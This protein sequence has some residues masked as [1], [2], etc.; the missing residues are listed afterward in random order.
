MKPIKLEIEGLN[1]YATKQVVDFETLTSRGLFGIFGKTGSGKS[2]ILDAITLS[3]YG[4][5][6]RGTKEFINSNHDKASID[7]EFELGESGKRAVYKVSRRFKRSKTNGNSL[8]DYARLVRKSSSG[9]YEILADKK[10]EVDK[11]IEEIIGLEE[12]D[13]LRSV[14][15][16][17]G[18]FSEFLTLAGKERRSMLERIF[19]LEEY[20]TELSQKI[21]K[22]RGKLFG[23]M[24]V[25]E[26]RLSEYPNINI[27]EKKDL[28]KEIELLKSQI[29]SLNKNKNDESEKYEEFSQV[30]NLL[31]EKKKIEQFLEMLI[32]N[33]E[34]IKKLSNKLEFSNK[35]KLLKPEV[36]K[37]KELKEKVDNLN[38]EKEELD[39]Q[40][41]ELDKNLKE[42]KTEFKEIEGKKN[43]M[44]FIVS[45]KKDIENI[46][47]EKEK[48]AK[49]IEKLYEVKESIKVL[50]SKK[51][52]I[53][54]DLLEI[55]NKEKE[56]DEKNKQLEETIKEN[57]INTEYRDLIY[58]SN[59]LIKEID[60]INEQ[61][62]EYEKRQALQSNDIEKNNSK[63]KDLT[64]KLEKTQKK[65][66][67]ILEAI[68]KEENTATPND[69]DLE[70]ISDEIYSLEK[71][72]IR[73]ESLN[74]KKKK[75]KE[76]NS[77]LVEK[78]KMM[79]I[80]LDKLEKSILD[81]SEKVEEYSKIDN[82]KSI[83]KLAS[84]IKEIWSESFHKGDI[85][86]VC[87]NVV[88]EIEL[89][90]YVEDSYNKNKKILK[91]LEE[92]SSKQ[93]MKKAELSSDIKNIN[94]SIEDNSKELLDIKGLYMNSS[95][96]DIISRID[97]LKKDRNEVKLQREDKAKKI[98]E[99]SEEKEK[100]KE[101]ENRLIIE[102]NK[103]SSSNSAKKEALDILKKDIDKVFEEKSRLESTFSEKKE[104]LLKIRSINLEIDNIFFEEEY[105]KIS[106]SIKLLEKLELEKEKNVKKIKELQE[107]I[108][109]IN[110]IKVNIEK[111]TAIQEN[112]LQGINKNIK[113][114][115]NEI[116][117]K[118]KDI[119]LKKLT[120]VI[121]FDCVLEDR[122]VGIL[123]TFIRVVEE[124]Y[125]EA[126]RYLEEEEKNI[127]ILSRKIESNKTLRQLQNENLLEQKSRVEL[128]LKENKFED[129]K[130]IEKYYLD[131]ESI[132]SYEEDIKKFNESLSENKMK[133]KSL[134]EKL[135]GRNVSKEEKENQ[136]EVLNEI[137]EKLDLSKGELTKSVYRLAE[138]EKDLKLVE[139]ILKEQK[140]N[141]KMMDDI[142]ELEK[143]FKGNRFIE[144]LSQIYLK[145]I[146]FDASKR[147]DSITNGRY[148]LE[149]NS[150]YLFVIRDNFNGGIRR[151]AD[152]LSGGEIFLTSLS[153]A[154]ALSSQIQ[155]KGSAPLEFFFLDE[156][157][158]TL[159]SSLLETV[160]QSLEK[161]SSDTLSVG[162]ISHVDEIK[163]RIPMK[164][165]VEM[166]ESISSS[167]IHHVLD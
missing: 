69:N 61:N 33:E 160:M 153:L 6:A 43:D 55:S 138:M 114:K 127:E 22:R 119:D 57:K 76:E 36:E 154:L 162:I 52:K 163:T 28:E 82:E 128:L 51:E 19:G 34:N 83:E 145:N 151:S 56:I 140:K 18:K 158:G 65:L 26:A 141:S 42:I 62:C 16:P 2:T 8:S 89:N 14:V 144:Y 47:E 25:L 102:K 23:E 5:I 31:E 147:L 139:D 110:L 46:I 7:Y 103:I 63:L 116:S 122:F 74:E 135:S 79:I 124:N 155:L 99:L 165:E 13:F 136:Q 60:K 11:K 92:N 111:E 133:L 84:Q 126:R 97:K 58:D 64:E 15:L 27:E 129:E 123:D 125:N 3:L 95:Y 143:V 29:E 117:K 54:N 77:N 113:S 37:L 152:T 72:A 132:N 24:E 112:E 149:I 81:N 68:S 21:Y 108:N 75:L 142:R 45:T 107:N 38:K 100:E 50:E 157:F 86:P 164:L 44:P 30:F 32:E 41:I 131:D 109:N 91:E 88:E 80:D 166:D 40:K 150:D 73:V 120:E 17:Q 78:K 1:S 101:N 53:E 90:E 39:R 20:G 118:E 104:K 167:V 137:L 134:N 98:L 35:A 156:G 146:V 70:K 94:K 66:E 130:D 49:N 9:E 48:Q 106:Q 10:T 96:E 85:C 115:S 148:S 59:L 4:N 87:N 121:E 161:L 159:D 67:N 12:S 93:M 71:E 105:V